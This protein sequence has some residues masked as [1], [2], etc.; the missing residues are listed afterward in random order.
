[1]VSRDEIEREEK[2]ESKYHMKREKAGMQNKR[3][4]LILEPSAFRVSD[5]ALRSKC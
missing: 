2:R 5:P 3:T 1:M 4:K